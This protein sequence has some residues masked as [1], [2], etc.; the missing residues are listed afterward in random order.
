MLAFSETNGGFCDCGDGS[1]YKSEGFC[2]H[3]NGVINYG[4]ELDKNLLIRLR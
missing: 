4:K 3:H 2:F 1:H